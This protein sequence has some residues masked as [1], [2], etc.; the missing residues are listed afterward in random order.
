MIVGEKDTRTVICY[1]LP[2][3]ADTNR[4]EQTAETQ[5]WPQ[6]YKTFS[7]L[8]SFEHE[9]LNAHKRKNTEKFSFFQAQINLECYFSFSYLLN[10]QQLLEFNIYEQQKCHTQLS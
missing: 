1:D 10:C 9:I 7:M 5:S 2:I 3:G 8:N 6:G 4:S